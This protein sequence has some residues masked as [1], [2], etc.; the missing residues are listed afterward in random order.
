LLN[1][2]KQEEI[3]N[4][5]SKEDKEK[6]EKEILKIQLNLLNNTENLLQKVSS[7]FEKYSQY[8]EK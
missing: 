1:E 3:K 5:I 2:K 8:E 4:N 6:I 7:N